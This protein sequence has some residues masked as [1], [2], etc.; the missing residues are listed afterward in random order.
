VTKQPKFDWWIMSIAINARYSL[1][2]CTAYTNIRL[3]VLFGS[4]SYLFIGFITNNKRKAQQA[5]WRL[6]EI[7]NWLVDEALPWSND[8][9]GYHPI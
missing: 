3:V 5:H 8:Q 9:D 4:C 2:F 7:F 1:Y 6:G